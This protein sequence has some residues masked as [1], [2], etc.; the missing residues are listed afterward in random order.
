MRKLLCFTLLGRKL[1]YYEA[2]RSLQKYKTNMIKSQKIV[3]L[4]VRSRPNESSANIVFRQA[5]DEL[6]NFDNQKEGAFL[7]DNFFFLLIPCL[8]PDGVTI[9]NSKCSLSGQDLN[10]V[11]GRPD[12]YLHPEVFYAKRLLKKLKK[13]NQI[14]FF[15]EFH[16][17]MSQPACFM[18]GN[19]IPSNRKVPR[20]FPSLM[21]EWCEG[22]DLKQCKYTYLIKLRNTANQER[23]ESR[24]IV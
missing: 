10:R 19:N 7:R 21:Y 17:N 13:N 12:K 23:I 16:A 2:Y 3:V 8:N 9:G 14:I 15:T 22:F 5:M 24:D 20:E 4:F 1:F 18:H 11:W 6:F